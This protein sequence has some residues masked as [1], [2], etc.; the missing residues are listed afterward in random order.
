[1]PPDGNII[2]RIQESQIKTM[3][4]NQLAINICIDVPFE[5]IT[6]EQKTAFIAV[7]IDVLQGNSPES[8]ECKMRL[9]RNIVQKPMMMGDENR[10]WSRFVNQF[11]NRGNTNIQATIAFDG[12]I[13]QHDKSGLSRFDLINSVF[14]FDHHPPKGR[15]ALEST[16][17][18]VLTIIRN[19]LMSEVGVDLMFHLCM[20]AI[21]DN[22]QIQEVYCET[23]S[24]NTLVHVLLNRFYQFIDVDEGALAT[25]LKIFHHH[26]QMD[27]TCGLDRATAV[28]LHTDANAKMCD[29]L[30]R[31][32][33]LPDTQARK[34]G[35]IISQIMGLFNCD[36]KSSLLFHEYTSIMAQTLARFD[37]LIQS[38]DRVSEPNLDLVHREFAEAGMIPVIDTS[39]KLA[40]V[41]GKT[42]KAMFFKD[43]RQFKVGMF[44][45]TIDGRRGIALEYD[46]CIFQK[47]GGK[48][49][50]YGATENLILAGYDP[51]TFYESLRT[52][53]MSGAGG[54]DIAGGGQSEAE[55]DMT[56]VWN[57]FTLSLKNQGFAIEPN[58]ITRN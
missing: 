54:A 34:K 8:Q 27:T 26:N 17:G 31:V 30:L 45:D 41:D 24:D 53:G 44:E 18:Q 58:Q 28:A 57:L 51:S 5:V 11:E 47:P 16:V 2:P 29:D 55:V 13:Y 35:A 15:L 33:S 4:P 6:K 9:E 56:I 48:A 1:M 39:Y 10:L 43:G 3:H 7:V 50:S 36:E 14:S 12:C 23:D 46:G 20:A 52:A 21:V 32:L 49:M 25:I 19:Y 37:L 42:F 38:T 22:Y 40:E